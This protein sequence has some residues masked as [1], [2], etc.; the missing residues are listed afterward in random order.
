MH[1]PWLHSFSTWVPTSVT[2][3]TARPGPAFR[4]QGRLISRSLCTHFLREGDPIFQ[5]LQRL[6]LV[7]WSYLH[8]WG[9][10]PM[11]AALRPRGTRLHASLPAAC[12][13]RRA[14]EEAGVLLHDTTL[15][16]TLELKCKGSRR[17]CLLRCRHNGSDTGTWTCSR[18]PKPLE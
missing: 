12:T 2:V 15:T 10:G 4:S 16:D 14:G 3:R 18:H 7:L 17:E 9:R 8:S 1:K 6:A 5:H 13:A 11:R